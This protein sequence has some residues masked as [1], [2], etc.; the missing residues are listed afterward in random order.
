[1]FAP[2]RVGRRDNYGMV[3][4]MGENLLVLGLQWGDEG[5]GK[6]ID[7]LSGDFDVV[8]R[9]QGGAN[10]GHTVQVKEEKFVLHLIPSGILHPGK[11]CI[12][13]NGVVVD[14]QC[15]LEEIDG[16]EAR[17]IDVS[18]L[19]LSDRAHVV[20][21]YHKVLDS[22]RE[23]ALGKRKIATT[24]RG[25][26]PCYADKAARCGVRVVDMMRPATLRRKLKEVLAAKNKELVQ[27]YGAEPI[28]FAEVFAAYE[29][30]AERLKPYVRDTVPLV[31]DLLEKGKSI[32]LEGAQ[33]TMLDINFGTYPYVTS[34]NVSAGGA[35]VGTG[36]PPNRIKRVMGVVKAYSS[37]VGAGPFPTE[38]DND[39]GKTIR[40]R[41]HEYGSTTG[42]PRRCGW[43]DGVALR[44]A[45]SVNAPDSI[46]V[47][48]MDVLSVLAELKVCVAYKLNGQEI[49]NFPADPDHLA[50]AE[51]VYETF[52]GW[53]TDISG[54]RSIDKLPRAA[55]DYLAAVEEVTGARA[56]M[57]SVGPEREQIARRTCDG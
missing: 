1:M 19:I 44:H 55:R 47:M 31:R 6:V 27:L 40:E 41:G 3:K 16:L 10:A 4:G 56:E 34:S 9:F 52:E 50:E 54:V 7:A 5:K 33:G 39:I 49:E 30:Y 28:E 14:P 37:R 20:M 43:L 51:P 22:L 2:R 57:V 53:Q 21:P 15:L 45:A 42:R 11:L 38:Q 48:L 23:A 18:G 32:L 12:V 26:G 8:V 36:I 46:A 29:A 35:A 25:I 13:G 24:G 17:G